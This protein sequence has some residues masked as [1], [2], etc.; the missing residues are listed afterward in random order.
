MTLPAGFQW[1]KANQN[2]P[3]GPNVVACDHRWVAQI[4]ERVDGGGWFA[5]LDIQ[6]EAGGR[7]WRVRECTSEAAGRAGIEAWVRRHQERLVLEV[8]QAA[9]LKE[10]TTTRYLNDS[11]GKPRSRDARKA[12]VEAGLQQLQGSNALRNR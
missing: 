4:V 12:W 8:Q 7:A 5:R 6:R 9:R 3:G 11:L 10:A 2:A 1:I